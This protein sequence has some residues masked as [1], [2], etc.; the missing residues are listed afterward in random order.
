MH[1]TFEILGVLPVL[2]FFQYQAQARPTMAAYIG[3]RRCTLDG[4]L[5]SLEE[6]NPNWDLEAIT[7]T[8]VAFWLHNQEGIHRWQQRLRDAGQ[9][10]LVV[11]RLSDLGGLRQEFEHL[12]RL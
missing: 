1:Y 10:S 5:G 3:S 6:V 11:A 8:V 12:L 2:Q 9:S 4:F 7:Q